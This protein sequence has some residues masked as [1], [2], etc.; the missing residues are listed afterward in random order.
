LAAAAVERIGEQHSV[1]EGAELD[2]ITAQH[3]AI[4]LEVLPDLEDRWVLQERLHQLQRLPERDLLQVAVAEIEAAAGAV[5]E[6]HVA[7]SAGCGGEREADELGLHGV[8]ARRLDVEG[9]TAGGTGLGE[10]R[11]E[12]RQ[13]GYRLI[14]GPIDLRL[15]GT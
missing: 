5:P 12:P 2:A 10:P 13:L 15:G 4:V 7:G 8:E 14:L 6:R 3:D 9:E 11:L 1:V